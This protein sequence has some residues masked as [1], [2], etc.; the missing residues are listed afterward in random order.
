MEVRKAWDN[1]VLEHCSHITR[2]HVE[3][4]F[5][6]GGDLNVLPRIED[7]DRGAFSNLRQTLPPG[8]TPGRSY[9]DL[10]AYAEL[11]KKTGMINIKNFL[12][13]EARLRTQWIS[14]NHKAADIGQTCDHILATKNLINT[15]RRPDEEMSLIL[16]IT[17]FKI[18]QKMGGYKGQSDHCP[19]GIELNWICPKTST[20]SYQS[21]LLT[22]GIKALRY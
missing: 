2:T 22:Q 4:S 7:V 20:R 18:K 19:I 9:D 3:K 1:D 5:A 15:T 14:P 12:N 11:L 13:H 10:A 21:S 16:Q 6:Y 17:T 8:A